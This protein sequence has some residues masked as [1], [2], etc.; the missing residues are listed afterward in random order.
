VSVCVCVEFYENEKSEKS[1][2]FFF[3]KENKESEKSHSA[4]SCPQWLGH[5]LLLTIKCFLSHTMIK[6]LHKKK[7]KLQCDGSLFTLGA[8]DPILDQIKNFYLIW[9]YILV[10]IQHVI[11]G[12]EIYSKK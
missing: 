9:N 2:F 3:A 1:F 8:K 12:W 6:C 5:H 4:M 11:V 10:I 7:Q